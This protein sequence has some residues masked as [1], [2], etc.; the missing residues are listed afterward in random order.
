[1]SK[2]EKILQIMLLNP[3]DWRVEDIKTI[4][5]RYKIDYR[6]P[7]TSHVTFRFENDDKLTVLAH[8]HR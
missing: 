6:Q 2:I 5:K 1:M 3:L 4:A 8:K 7:G